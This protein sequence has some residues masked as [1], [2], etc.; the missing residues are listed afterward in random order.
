MYVSIS[1]G[2]TVREAAAAS[3][4][5]RLK[6]VQDQIVH[7]VDAA[8]QLIPVVLQLVKTFTACVRSKVLH[9]KVPPPSPEG[10]YQY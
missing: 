10:M 8:Q 6:D 5:E 1:L 7:A 2:Q 3:A 9:H 4:L